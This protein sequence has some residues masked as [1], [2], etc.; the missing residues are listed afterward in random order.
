MKTTVIYVHPYDKSFN[1]AILENYIAHHDE[2][3]LTVIDLYKD[4]FNPAY[5]VEELALFKEGKTKDSLVSIYQD[6]LLQTE[7]IVIITPIWWNNIPAILKGFFDKVF[8][9]GFAYENANLGV[10]GKLGHI[11]KVTVITTA[12]SPKFYLKYFAG[13]CINGSVK[14]CFKQVGI[15][16]FTWKHLGNIG[17]TSPE[18]RKKFLQCL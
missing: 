6:I 17:K 4:N 2:D 1:H 14:T 9:Q 11:K 5:D 18:K 12:T 16:K 13:N 3:E 10:T 15:K 8:K 7:E